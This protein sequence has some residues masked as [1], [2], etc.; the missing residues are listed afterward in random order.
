MVN[1]LAVTK[2]ASIFVHGDVFYLSSCPTLTI[3]QFLIIYT[4]QP[5]KEFILN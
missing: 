5:S 4:Q 2:W 3:L 1:G